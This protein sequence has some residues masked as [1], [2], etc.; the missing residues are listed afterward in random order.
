MVYIGG[1]ISW[2]LW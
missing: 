1:N 2:I